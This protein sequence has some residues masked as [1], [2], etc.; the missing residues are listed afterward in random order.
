MYLEPQYSTRVLAEVWNNISE[1]FRMITGNVHYRMKQMLAQKS[2]FTL[3]VV[4]LTE[5]ASE[6]IAW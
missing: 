6:K 2:S 1:A 4:S 3:A 5:I